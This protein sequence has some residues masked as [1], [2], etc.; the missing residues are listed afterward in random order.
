MAAWAKHAKTNVP[1]ISQCIVPRFLTMQPISIVNFLCFLIS[2]WSSLPAIQTTSDE[3]PK[4]P[5]G[6]DRV[7]E[8]PL[9]SWQF[10]AQGME[11]PRAGHRLASHKV[12]EFSFSTQSLE[13][14]RCK[15]SAMFG[16]LRIGR[17]IYQDCHTTLDLDRSV[18]ISLEEIQHPTYNHPAKK[19]D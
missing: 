5:N 9:L 17:Q 1:D 11:Q 4:P 2:V 10:Q 8:K 14:M 3:P 19:R 15:C 16:T 18:L 7:H 6:S 12:K 13:P